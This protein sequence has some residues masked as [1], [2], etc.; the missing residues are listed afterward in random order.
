MLDPEVV[1]V[2]LGRR[3][4][5]APLTGLS[6]REKEILGLMAEGRSNHAIDRALYLSTKTVETHLRNIFTKLGL[7]TAPTTTDGSSPSSCYLGR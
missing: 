2:F 1:A 7:L 6:V 4:H 3:R 5:H